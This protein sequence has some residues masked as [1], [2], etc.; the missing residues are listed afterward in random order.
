MFP[1][2]HSLLLTRL[3]E[4][5]FSTRLR[6]SL[7]LQHADISSRARTQL[8]LVSIPMLLGVFAGGSASAQAAG[9]DDPFA[10]VEEMIVTGGGSAA[11]LA[12]A[13]T[14]AIAF[15]SAALEAHGIEDLSDISAQVPNLAIRTQDQTNASF[16]IRGVGLQDFGANASSSVPIFQ[17]GIARNPS[18]TQLVGLY[19]IQGLNV[20]KGPQ[21]SGN[22]RNASAGAFL[23]KT[24]VPEPE[25]S[26][27]AKVSYGRIS[28]VDARDANRYGFETAMNAPIYGDIIS[29]RIAARYDHENPFFEN[30]CANRTE[31]L[32]RP[33]RDDV[34]LEAA[35]ICGETFQSQQGTTRTGRS[36]VE[37]FLGRFL[38]E[39]DDWGMRGS[40]RIQPPDSNMD[41]VFRLEV[42]R[43]NRDATVGQNI[44]VSNNL[45]Q[46]GRQDNGS[47]I[48][49][50][51]ELRRLE[52]LAQITAENPGLRPRERRN[53]SYDLLGKEL[54]KDP[55]DRNPYR[56][57]FDNPGR[58]LLETYSASTTGTI[59]FDE[60]DL[61]VNLGY[62]DYRKSQRQ[63]T[64]VSSNRRFP[65]QGND[66][67][68]E[69]YGSL[70]F[71]G[72][73]IGDFP[74]E[75]DFGLYSMHEKVEA[76]QEQTVND[77]IRINKF[78]QEIY[79]FGVFAK[80]D[81]EIFEGFNLSAGARYNWERKDFQVRATRDETPNG[82]I[83]I[84][85][86]DSGNQRTWDAVTG[87][88]TLR[89]DFTEEV[90]TYISYT[91][92]FKAGHFNPSRPDAKDPTFGF[93][94]P[95]R[96]DS[97]EW[98]LSLEA[99]ANRVKADFGI[100]YYN[101][102]NYQV[103][104]LTTT[105]AGV[106]RNI[107][108]ARQA[109]NYGAEL[110]MTVTPLE[111]YAPEI[112]EGLRLA[113]KIGWLETNFTE[114]TV[115]EFR[116]FESGQ[117]SVPINY[118]GNPLINSANLEITGTVT[119]PIATTRF[120][121]FTPQYD[122]QWFDDTPFDPN[123]GRGELNPLGES[124]LPPAFIGN[125]AYIL[126]NVRL[127]WEPPGDSGLKLAGW[128]RNLED[129]RYKTF[130]VDISTFS[131]QTLNY[132]ADPRLCGVEGTFSF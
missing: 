79:S 81:Y 25:F 41:W 132:V 40:V 29:M 110:E 91:R 83:L 94:D 87:F 47:Y 27:M 122:F 101:Y 74:I 30:G 48:D 62:L 6:S 104:R 130:A 36:H 11:L 84:V 22:F 109:R 34:G 43:L 106:F 7:G 98:H 51:I 9:G 126:H 38:N 127:S 20:L 95:E 8:L 99:W 112:V 75:W 50:D 52:L 60:F 88:A 116:Q 108:S 18:A 129:R 68:Y 42:S 113:V 3:N 97:V 28:S 21:G 73:V 2:L 56:G 13:N 66:Q 59:E 119:W 114:F 10:G 120:G 39:V 76:F 31:I 77:A 118:A 49:P 45:R 61:E 26:G 24:R 12:P 15:D 16:F 58:T 32:D 85:D 67:A 80:F 37:P 105:G 23:I 63:D 82:G 125:R 5:H 53:L 89:Y 72:E 121:T 55:L 54:Y 96:I 131:G 107:E 93:A 123:N 64:D 33:R 44:G 90:G 100:F 103:F 124:V 70:D 1:S 86:G 128:C 14:S 17:D 4:S 69:I 57:D 102:K 92:G 111:G 65:S 115:L 117:I 19:D 46:I 78:S 71:G 35:R